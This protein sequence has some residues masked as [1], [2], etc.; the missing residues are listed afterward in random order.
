[1]S[2]AKTAKPIEMPFSGLTHVGPRNHI[3][4]G[5]PDPPT[6]R[7]TF[8]GDMCRRIITYLRMGA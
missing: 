8:E 5:N 3:L 7:G 2:C 6:G 4:D 1:M